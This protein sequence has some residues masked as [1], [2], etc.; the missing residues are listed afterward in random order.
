MGG[1]KK[2]GSAKMET[3]GVVD[4]HGLFAL[5]RSFCFF[6]YAFFGSS[7]NVTVLLKIKFSLVESLS[8]QK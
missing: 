2:E 3:H 5:R 8:T 1:K 4:V 6:F 7:R